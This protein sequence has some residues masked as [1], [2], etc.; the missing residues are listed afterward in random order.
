MG[1]L[2]AGTEPPDVVELWDWT[3][4]PGD[5]HTSEAHAAGTKE[6]IHVLKGTVA[7]QV[8]DQSVTLKI[9]DAVAF[10][11]DVEHSYANAQTKSA[12]F[13]LT[14]FEPGVGQVSRSESHDA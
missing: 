8:A 10:S 13:S 1:V 14:V 7:V 4:G 9:G 12:R 2:V 3:L 11:G 6:L 5:V